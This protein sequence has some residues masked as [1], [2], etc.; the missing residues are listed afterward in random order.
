MAN[1]RAPF[2][3]QSLS[4]N[5]RTS[6][7]LQ[8]LYSRRKASTFNGMTELSEDVEPLSSMQT[9]GPSA[10]HLASF[11]PIARSK[12]RKRRLPPSR[13][14]F[15]SPKYYR[16]P[17]HP[18]QPPPPTDPSS[19]EFIPGPFSLPRL[20]QTYHSTLAPDLLTLMYKHH[21]PGTLPGPS[22][23]RLRSWDG[24]SPYFK[25][26]P[27]RGPRGGPHLPLLRRPITFRNIPRL[28]KIHVHAFV[29][30]AATDSA[31]LHVAGMV[32]QAIT[33]ARATV[34]RAK[35]SIANFNLKK[36]KPCAV[37]VEL[38]GEEMYHFLA[39]VTEVVMPR[40][41]DYKG[42]SGKSGDSSGN[43]AWGFGSDAVGSFPEVEVNYDSYPPKM[44]PEIDIT[45]C[46]TATNDKDAR[47]LLSAMG[48]PFHGKHVN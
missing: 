23:P 1:Q 44:I 34:F 48:V 14:Q 32:V 41:K 18:H 31:P 45:V 16:G 9:P 43:I 37:G 30:G 12:R 24:P 40:I 36:D 8:C 46:T 38:R 42:V 4:L 13:Y 33:G 6:H 26:R 20:Q 15:R 28:D 22:R 47:L 3:F 7:S 25:N 5:K 29:A 21:P 2:L 19:R 39:K 27:L 17:L 11:D 10:E 35:H